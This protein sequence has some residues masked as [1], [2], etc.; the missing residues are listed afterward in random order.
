MATTNEKHGPGAHYS[1]FNPV[2]N[3][4]RFIE[5][6]DKD[7]KERDRL[8][9]KE[10]AAK[11][12]GTGDAKPHKSG[13]ST[14]ATGTSKTVTDPIT[15]KAVEIENVNASFMKAVENPQVSYRFMSA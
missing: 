7:K 5:S 2:P 3:I 8:I 1:G 14:G 13:Q 11:A 12:S 10:Q 9:E 6:L 4:Q 15:G